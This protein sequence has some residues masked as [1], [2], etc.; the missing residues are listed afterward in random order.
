MVADASILAMLVLAGCGPGP[1]MSA[2]P[3]ATAPPIE[4]AEDASVESLLDRLDRGADD[5]RDFQAEITY[6][7]WDGVL[8]RN[9]VRHGEVLYKAED[10]LHGRRFA[11]LLRTVVV[12][13]RKR[14][15]HKDY[16]FDGSWLVEIDHEARLFLKRQIVPPGKQFDPLKL[17]EGPFPM[18]LGQ[19]KNEVLARFEVSRL[20]APTDEALASR[21]VGVNLEGLLLTPKPGTLEA[22]DV[23]RLELFYDS[24]TLLPAGI[25]LAETGGDRKT[26]VLKNARRNA[27]IDDAR[28]DISDPDPRE[29]RIDVRPWKE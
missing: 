10:A 19:P 22:K 14:D 13:N 7:K 21:L 26:V 9:E 5:L 27:G 4:Q 18:P 20:S 1:A 6:W 17:G 2:P 29:W 25:S 12:A 16:I 3:A 28:L 8:Q 24:A 11:I 15:Q 23:E